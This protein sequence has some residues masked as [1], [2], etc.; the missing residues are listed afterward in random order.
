MQQENLLILLKMR[1]TVKSNKKEQIF[2]LIEEYFSSSDFK[3]KKNTNKI[4]L[5]IPS[6]NWEEV[7]EALDSLLST[8]VT[9]GK[10]VKAFENL[11]A[12]YIGVK[13][14]IMVNSGSSANLLALS[15]LANPTTKNFIKKGD[16]VIVPAVTWSTSIFPIINVGAIPV[17]VDVSSES[18]TINLEQVEKALTTKTKAIMPV[19]LLGS[20]CNMKK[21]MTIAKKHDLFV[22]EDA[23]E[24]TGSEFQKKKV[25]SFGDI[26]TF[27]FFFS[28]HISTIEGGMLLTNNREYADLAKILRAHGW[29]RELE[30]K[31]KIAKSYIGI[32][33]RFLFINIGYNLRPTDIQGAFGIH[34][35]KKLDKFIEIRR[36]NAE[37][38]IN[39]LK[40]Y[41]KYLQMPSEELSTKHVWFGF[42]LTVTQNAPFTR[43]EFV[44]FLEKKGIETRPIMAGNISEQPVM[45][46][47][48]H[49]VFGDIP[50]S[51]IIQKRSFLFGLHQGIGSYERKYIVNTINE[52]MTDRMRK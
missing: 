30:N 5:N 43:E 28:H 47:F 35:I 40:K 2:D 49:Y 14:A 16:E 23:C 12:E 31:E 29:I 3:S 34:Q 1:L 4:P 24:S 45:K 44:T 11:F 52:F 33:K 22:I 17:F 15:I 42:P 18:F 7:T 6:Y 27:S 9:M 46:L 19:H 20:A 26:S 50:N 37:F 41:S 32:D 25:G 39:N 8:Y 36:Q 21:I 51:K 10:K 13:Y 48:K 38:F